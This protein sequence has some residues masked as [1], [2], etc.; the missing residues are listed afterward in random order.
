MT[1]T[2]CIVV[3]KCYLTYYYFDFTSVALT[4]VSAMVFKGVK[5]KRKLRGCSRQVV[6]TTWA[7]LGPMKVVKKAYV[8]NLF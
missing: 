5:A 6:I 8:R 1:A 2:G 3:E 4:A 7:M